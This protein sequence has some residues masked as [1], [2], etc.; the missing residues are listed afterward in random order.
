MNIEKIVE[1][2]AVAGAPAALLNAISDIQYDV[3]DGLV[4][5]KEGLAKASR[6]ADPFLP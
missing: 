2:A 5:E 6:L 4:T 3:E 1:A